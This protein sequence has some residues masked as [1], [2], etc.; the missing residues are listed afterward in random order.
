MVIVILNNGRKISA[1]FCLVMFIVLFQQTLCPTCSCEDLQQGIV[2][3][4]Y[5]LR[6]EI[7]LV[8]MIACCHWS[9]VEPLVD[10][11][12]LPLVDQCW[13]DEQNVGIL[14]MAA[15]GAVLRLADCCLTVHG[16]PM[17][18]R[19]TL[20]RIPFFKAFWIIKT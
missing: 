20:I 5:L 6:K 11:S 2:S 13:L 17:G 4:Y 16:L 1:M 8:I 12:W 7:R 19:S 14:L 18:K 3:Y 15:S 10:I 9:A